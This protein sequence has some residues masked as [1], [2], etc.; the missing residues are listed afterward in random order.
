MIVSINHNFNLNQ[1]KDS[2]QAF[3]ITSDNNNVFTFIY[4]DHVLRIKHLS[5]DIYEVS[6][7]EYEWNHIWVDYFDLNTDYSYASHLQTGNEFLDN[8]I[9]FG[10][11][12]RILKQDPFEIFVSY[13]ISQQSNIPRIHSIVNKLCKDHGKELEPGI[14]A[15]P[16]HQD[17]YQL[18]ENDWRNDYHLGYR[19]RY[20]KN[21]IDNYTDKIYDY[22]NKDNNELFKFAKS[23]LGIGDKIASCIMLFAYHRL[24]FVPKDVWIKRVIETKFNGINLFDCYPGIEG[25][26]QQY[27]YY[28]ARHFNI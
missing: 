13:I 7:S 28:Y 5:D 3:H 10:N 24:N 22:H 14:Y 21:F 25:I 2:G 26:L 1:I 6:V 19:A 11:G 17:L 16:S 8:A 9:I 4:L 15:F 23:F 27:V 12:I 18:S 20:L